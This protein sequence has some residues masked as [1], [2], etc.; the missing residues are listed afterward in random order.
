MI[1]TIIGRKLQ[2]TQKF[3]IDGTRIPVTIIDVADNPVMAIKT[4]DKH[5]YSAIQI[6]YGNRK[7]ASKSLIAYAKSAGLQTVPLIIREV[8]TSSADTVP[9]IGD[10]V[11]AENILKAGDIVK[12]SGISKGKGFA[13][14]VKRHNFRGGPRTH[15]Q[16]DRERAP[17]S[18]G[19]TTTPGRVYRGKKMAG[20]MGNEKV[21]VL[22]LQIVDINVHNGKKT[23]MVK[24]LVPGSVNSIVTIE[25]TGSLP[26]KKIIGLVKNEKLVNTENT[27]KSADTEVNFSGEQNTGQSVQQPQ[28]GS[29]N[30]SENIKDKNETAEKK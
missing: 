13:G 4:S 28:E 5:G 21:S 30:K 10:L 27:D 24:G 17:G 12:V 3:L 7:K 23:I 20:R 22:H 2:Q 15:G 8:R 19:Q 26:E 29:E 6:G 9:A 16:S 18:I 25:K 11:S 14:V 1:N